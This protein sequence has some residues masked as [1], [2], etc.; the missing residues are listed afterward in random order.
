MNARTTATGLRRG[1][2]WRAKCA[3]GASLMM[4]LSLATL[5]TERDA[6]IRQHEVGQRFDLLQAADLL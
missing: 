1:T 2:P 6:V 3:A 4:V 5:V